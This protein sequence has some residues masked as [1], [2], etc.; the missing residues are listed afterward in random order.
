MRW[1]RRLGA[2][3]VLQVAV[4]GLLSCGRVH[5]QREG[6]YALFV[7]EIL[8]DGC[9]LQSTLGMTFEGTLYLAGNIAWFQ[10]DDALFGMQLRGNFKE[11]IE[12]F[13]LDGS[14]SN[15]LTPLRAATCLLDETFIHLAAITD[16]AHNFHDAIRLTSVSHL[17]SNCRSDL[18]A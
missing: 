16:A 18:C 8:R 15:M 12:Q 3:F 5:P 6:A 1:N 11:N 14:V 17:N 2:G 10:L 7:T 9:N 13:H 4:S